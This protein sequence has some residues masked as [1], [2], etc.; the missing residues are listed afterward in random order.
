MHCLAS[1]PLKKY[2]LKVKCKKVRERRRL[3][4][5]EWDFDEKKKLKAKMWRAFFL[6]IVFYYLC[7]EKDNN[8]QLM[9]AFSN[10]I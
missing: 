7:G 5:K 4:R 3:N 8:S 2:K 1:C 9:Q 6:K 10:D